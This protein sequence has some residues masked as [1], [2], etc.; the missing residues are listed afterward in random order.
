[1]TQKNLPPEERRRATLKAVARYGGL[2]FELLGA[3]LAGVFIGRWADAKI[4]LEKPA[5]AVFLTIAFLF[6]ALYRIYKQLL[7]D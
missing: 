6:A 5:F 2:A 4:G 1:M 7:K 3:C